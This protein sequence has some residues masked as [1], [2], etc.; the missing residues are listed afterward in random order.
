MK[1]R[2]LS[3]GQEDIFLFTIDRK[4][5]NN[6]SEINILVDGGNN[7][8]R[9]VNEIKDL[10]LTKLDYI[11]LT[12][13]DNDHIQGIL[14]ILRTIKEFKDTIIVYNKFVNGLVSYTQA[15]KFER[16]IEKKEVIVS[17]KEYQDNSGEITFLSVDQRRKMRYDNDRV[18]ITFLSPDRDKVKKL[19][20]FYDFYKTTGRKQSYDAEIV[21]RSSIIFILEYQQNAILM[22]GDGY[23]S[24]ILS[25][26]EQ[27]SNSTQ[28]V[29]PIKHFDLIKIPHH[30]SKANN[31]ELAQLVQYIPCDKFVIT[32]ENSG[33]VKISEELK[34]V[35]LKKELYI[36]EECEKCEGMC[37]IVT[38]EIEVN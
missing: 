28:T 12:H 9:C 36:S 7:G 11:V 15:E 18:Y 16:L 32:N 4:I 37:V 19:Y 27:L 6:S 25:S 21:N 30:G 17:Y 5:G 23:I 13:I 1:I 2:N 3:N 29:H 24:D 14:M 10:G 31:S 22:T 8:I 26:I 20:D 34:E 35:L 33:S 38:K